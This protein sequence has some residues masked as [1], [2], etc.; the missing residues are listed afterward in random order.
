[1]I[2][3]LRVAEMARIAEPSAFRLHPLTKVAKRKSAGNMGGV[4][5]SPPFAQNRAAELLALASSPAW[6]PR[7]PLTVEA[8]RR[9]FEHPQPF[10]LGLEEELMV[11]D[12]GTL[13]LVPSADE[14]LELVPGDVRFAK[15]LRAAQLEIVTPVCMTAADACRELSAARRDLCDALDGRLRLLASGMHPFSTNYGAITHGERYAQIAD[16][17]A[18]AAKR[19]LVC[20][21]HIHVALAGA[22]RSLAVYNALRSYLPELAALGANSPF[23]EGREADMASVRPKFNEVYPR[24]GIPPA[25][26]RW[27]E[28]VDYLAWGRAGGLFPDASHLWWEMRPHPVHGTL[29]IRV[30]D[31]QTRVED[32][33]AIAAVVQALV[34]MLAAR[35]DVGEPLPRH[36]SHRIAENAWRAYR[37]GVHGWLVDLDDGARIPTRDR[38][39]GLL[40]ELEP[41]AAPFAAAEQIEEARILLAGNGAD[42]QRYVFARGGS[43]ELARW[44]ADE[45]EGSARD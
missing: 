40:E 4:T 17:Y 32:S 41:Y 35:Y 30:L 2:A 6:P 16:E 12:P 1:M 31:A 15:E 33:A 22:E 24:S 3:V 29:E 42:R 36:P 21:L 28:F 10:T 11:V 43:V 39:G 13:D 14:A 37:Y 18:W 20:G 7:P 23:F 25:F 27:E 19:S 45:T 9:A 8:I 34:A 26:E 5:S 38:L 44:L